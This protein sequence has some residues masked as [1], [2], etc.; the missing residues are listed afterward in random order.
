MKNIV[1]IIK[2]YKAVVKALKLREIDKN[3]C[4]TKFNDNL[5]K[6]LK[7]NTILLF[8][9]ERCVFI[10]LTLYTIVNLSI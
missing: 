7:K 9:V 3:S 1:K 5:K 8:Q 4:T 6:S 2:M 10:Q